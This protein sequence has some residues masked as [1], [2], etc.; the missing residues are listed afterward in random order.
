LASEVTLR[1]DQQHLKIEE[2][3]MGKEAIWRSKW[4][5]VAG[6]MWRNREFEVND[7]KV[8]QHR[9]AG[10]QAGLWVAATTAG[11]QEYPASLQEHVSETTIPCLIH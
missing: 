4:E 11:S 3:L 9:D 1:L 2:Q 7:R 5:E 8:G 10:R 6:M